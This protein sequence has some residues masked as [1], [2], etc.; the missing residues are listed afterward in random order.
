MNATVAQSPK[1]ILLYIQMLW[2]GGI[3]LSGIY[4][5]DFICKY[6]K[7]FGASDAMLRDEVRTI[8]YFA[9]LNARIA[10]PFESTQDFTPQRCIATYI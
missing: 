5:L 8:I 7:A 2:Y 9:A 6:D 1:F 3:A 10:V 4:P